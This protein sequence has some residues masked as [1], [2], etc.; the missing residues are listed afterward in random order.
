MKPC[1]RSLKSDKQGK[2]VWRRKGFNINYA[3]NDLN[4]EDNPKKYYKT[5]SFEYDFTV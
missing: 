5:L 4:Y 2:R 3:I 1:V